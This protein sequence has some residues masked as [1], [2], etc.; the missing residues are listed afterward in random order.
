[1]ASATP[2]T[3]PEAPQ[4]GPADSSQTD[5]GTATI[6]IHVRAETEG[7]VVVS[8]GNRELLRQSFTR[9]SV[10]RGRK[11]EKTEANGSVEIPAG[12]VE[13]R[14]IVAPEG[15]SG[16]VQRLPQ[17]LRSGS[18]HRLDVTLTELQGSASFN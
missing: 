10:F 15:K 9:T 3:S 16:K 13:L 2:L 11:L 1:M 14:V 5:S 18:T 8:V 4:P 17:N 6:H 7:T 12:N